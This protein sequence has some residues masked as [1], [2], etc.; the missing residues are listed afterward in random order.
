VPAQPAS[1]VRLGLDVR[2]SARGNR[3]ELR[4][5]EPGRPEGPPVAV[6]RQTMRSLKD[7]VTFFAGEDATEALVSHV[8]RR[9]FNAGSAHDVSDGRGVALG[10]FRK[11]LV[12]SIGRPT[13]HLSTADGLDAM[14]RERSRP[15]SALRRV[16]SFF[17]MP[18]FLPF[19]VDFRL[20]SGEVVLTCHRRRGLR[21]RYEITVPTL[22]DGRTLDW[23]LAVAVTAGIAAAQPEETS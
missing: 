7:E 18:V 6:A 2:I 10:E 21:D 13:W 16:F 8:A 17:E 22:A 9:A 1:P 3:Y 11:D 12:R 5:L 23:R 15:G 14:G 4:R 19:H 20:P